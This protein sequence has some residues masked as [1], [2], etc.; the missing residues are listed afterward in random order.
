VTLLRLSRAVYDNLRAHA[1]E[2]YPH[3]C[4]GA[5]LGRPTPDSWQIV[6][7]ARTTNIRA[8]SA[9]DRYEIAPAELISIMRDARSRGLEIAGFCHSH[10]DHPAQWSAT[11]LAE[12]HWVGCLYVIT[13][14]EHGKAG[15]TR[16]FLLAGITEDDKRFE[17]QD[18]HVDDSRP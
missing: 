18:L 1:E 3:E 5:L 11:D 16:A 13:A 12:A 14:V 2:S 10:P 4:C 8:G 6:S 15:L 17:P 9:R 7:L